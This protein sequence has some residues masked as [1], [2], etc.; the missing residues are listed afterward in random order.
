MLT[1][2]AIRG[3]ETRRGGTCSK[4]RKSF[5]RETEMPGRAV[6]ICVGDELLDGRVEDTNSRYLQE[7]LESLGWKV[8]LV[9]TVGDS[10]EDISSALRHALGRGDLVI[11]AGGLG[12]TPDDLTREGVADALGRKLVKDSTIE[13]VLRRRFESMGREMPPSNLKQAE[14]LEGDC[15]VIEGKGTAP[16]LLVRDS[17]KRIFL[18]PGVPSELREMVERSLVPSLDADHGGPQRMARVITLFGCTEAEA[19]EVA[20]SLLTPGGPVRASYLA[21]EGVIRVRLWGESADSVSLKGALDGLVE[22]VCE[23]LAGAVVST[24]G[25]SLPE[26]VAEMMQERRATLAV[27]ES[28]TGGLIGERITSVPGSSRFFLGGVIS[29]AMTVK[30]SVLGISR[31]L[32]EERG[33]VSLEVAE[34]M[35][36]K[37]RLMLGADLALSTTGVAGPVGGTEENPVGTVCIGLSHRGGERSWRLRFPGD[38]ELVR[39]LAANAALMALI[40]QLREGGVG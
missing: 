19:G 36:R 11:L 20:E 21:G 40:R 24:E 6:I 3:Q 27:A 31:R 37:V 28:C 34:E 30:T 22:K 32:L 12:P 23:R 10:R 14:V 29:Y 7:K 26:V 33:V 9:M 16:G 25:R 1:I 38:R 2:P 15:E 35:A 17:G 4:N 18:F 8:V 39:S 5:E 13:T